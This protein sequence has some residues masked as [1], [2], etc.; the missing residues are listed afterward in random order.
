MLV[1]A[2]GAT[3]TT[4]FDSTLIGNSVWLDGSADFFK[5]DDWAISADGRK[6]FIFSMWIQ[7]NEFGRAQ[8]HFDL[9]PTG[10]TS[11]NDGTHFIFAADDQ[12]G[13]SVANGS[14]SGGQK[15]STAMYRDIGWYHVLVSYNTNT[16]VVA[17]SRHR[18]FV[19]GLE[20]VDLSA[21]TAPSDNQSCLGSGTG[22]A[23]LRIGRTDH[24]GIPYPPNAYFAQACYLEGK[25][26]QAGDFAITDFLDSFTF[27]TNGSQFVPKADADIAAL[28]STV[29][30]N[31]FCLDFANSSDLGNDIS[32]NNKDLTPTSM[33]AANQSTNTPSHTYAVMDV[34]KNDGA[35]TSTMVFSEGSTRVTGTGGSDGGAYST[36]PLATTGTTEFQSTF[37]NGDG[38][39]GICCYDN[40]LAVSSSASRNVM[41]GLSVNYNAAYGYQ[42][43]G[44][45]VVMLSSGVTRSTQGAALTTNSV[46]TVRYD[47][48]SNE[49]TF[50]KD[51]AVQG[52]AVSTVAGLT[53]YV[54]VGRFNNYDITLHFDS[55]DF[56]HTIG[57]GNKT[58]NTA[59]LTAPTYQGIDYFAPTLYEGNGTGQ[60]VG[61]FVPFTDAFDVAKSAMFQHDEVRALK[62]TIGTPSSTGGKKG[63]WSTWYKTANIDTDNIFFDNGTTAT[64]RFTL[65]MDASGQI[66]FANGSASAGFS[67]SADLKGG[68]VWRNVVLKVDTSQSTA[69]DRA[70]IYID[71]VEVTSFATDTRSSLTQDSEIGYM[72]SGATQ[73]VGSYNGSSANQWDGYLAETIFLDNQFYQ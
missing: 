33:A 31:S 62:R 70:K 52:S 55:A 36:L 44:E 3:G 63:T 5:R 20:I 60:R 30:G 38:V 58:I 73:F 51:N 53:Y 61:D 41:G 64:N 22:N 57:S 71:G 47:A 11:Y 8:T 1:G 50:L 72:D 24:S 6:E 68:D 48:D 28:A 34:L 67:T 59:N 43:N 21:Y 12:L 2:A 4:P 42:E 37:N 23:D 54:F 10:H 39:V 25:S 46:V 17:T 35:N 45:K 29:G 66:F 40:L 13:F 7:R 32:S 14:G 18:V 9:I 19:N 16:S 56:P 26:F 27:G 49:I 69:T 15:I 65:Q